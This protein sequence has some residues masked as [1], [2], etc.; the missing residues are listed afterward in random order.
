MEQKEKARAALARRPVLFV[1]AEKRETK[2]T[3]REGEGDDDK[4]RKR[5]RSCSV[6]G[7]SSRSGETGGPTEASKERWVEIQQRMAREPSATLPRPVGRPPTKKVFE[8]F[9]FTNCPNNEEA[10]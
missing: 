3:R 5:G 8:R 9:N 6:I 10:L 1:E 7:R 4:G 2:E